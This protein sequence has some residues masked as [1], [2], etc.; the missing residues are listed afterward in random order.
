MSRRSACRVVLG[1]VLA[2][3]AGGHSHPAWSEA[4][5]ET[6]EASETTPLS[7]AQ[8]S[9]VIDSLQGQAEATRNLWKKLM[10]LLYRDIPLSTAQLN[11]TKSVIQKILKQREEVDSLRAKL[12]EAQ[13]A[14]KP[15]EIRELKAQLKAN[16]AQLRPVNRMATLRSILDPHQQSA[17]DMNRAIAITRL[18][19]NEL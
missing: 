3:M 5:S 7:P 12:A 19:R 8:W 6:L 2:V 15:D 13:E 1:I 11:E 18:R 4:P 16:G 14:V 17:F 10:P 9:E